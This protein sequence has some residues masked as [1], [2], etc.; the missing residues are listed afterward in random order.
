MQIPDDTQVGDL[1]WIDDEPVRIT[2]WNYNYGPF[3]NK[4]FDIEFVGIMEDGGGRSAASMIMIPMGFDFH[5][6]I[7]RKMSSL[8]KELF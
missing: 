8:E 3:L 1:V 7:I 2:A 4:Y 5:G 6:A